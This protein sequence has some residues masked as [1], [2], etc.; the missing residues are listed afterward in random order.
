M[1]FLEEIAVWMLS[2]LMLNNAAASLLNVDE[3]RRMNKSEWTEW[4]NNRMFEK[5]MNYDLEIWPLTSKLLWGHNCIII[6]ICAKLKE[7]LCKSKISLHY[8]F[9]PQYLNLITIRTLYFFR[10]V[11]TSQ[12]YLLLMISSLVYWLPIVDDQFISVLITYCWW[13]V[14]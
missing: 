2:L 7:N 5:W 9:K 4:L 14:H 10:P 1:Q 3:E 11:L 6:N 12:H 13:S 8:Y